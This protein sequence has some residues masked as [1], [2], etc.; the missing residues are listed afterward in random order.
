[1]ANL[2]DRS[3][4]QDYSPALDLST[5][6]D[7]RMVRAIRPETVIRSH[8]IATMSGETGY[9]LVD[10][11]VAIGGGRVLAV[12]S[13]EVPTSWCDLDSGVESVDARDRIILPGFVDAHTHLVH[14][15]SRENELAMKLADVPYLEILAKGG[16]IHGT[17][18]L[19]REATKEELYRK[20]AKSLDVMLE[21]G[22][23]TVEAKSGY[24]LDLVTE[25]KCLEVA[26]DL[27]R[28]HPIDVIS[29]YLGAHAVPKEYNGNTRAYMDFMMKTVM[30]FVRQEGLAE[31]M[32]VFC[33]AGVFSPEETFE[34]LQAGHGMG[35]GLK[36][37]ADEIV[38]LQGAEL[39]ARMNAVSADHL[40]AASDEGIAALAEFGVTAV[41]LPGTSFYLM[42]GKF[43]RARRMLES[44][45][46]VA[47]ASDYNPGTCPCENLQAIQVFACMGLRMTPEEILRGMTVN[48]A[49]ALRRADSVGTIEPGKKADLVLYDAPNPDWLVYH[50]GSNPVDVV[51]KSGRVV[52]R[53]GRRTT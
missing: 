11:W 12:E 38:P 16:G 17:V 13:G 29:T 27:D 33:E 41:L 30:P 23:T 46:R 42:T 28:T 34:L 52:V 49:H 48:A 24:G 2:S 31:F 50:F 18:R 1:M 39:A 51:Y 25:I 45:V 36:L 43:A 32:D 53:N 44:G 47:V 22:T 7:Q 21:H 15:G 5:E 19:T 3:V 14:A 10:G 35:F 9:G 4:R 20:A 40:L 6:P 8:R 37:H 26:R